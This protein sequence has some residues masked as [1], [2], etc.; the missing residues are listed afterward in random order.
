MAVEYIVL[1]DSP[2]ASGREEAAIGARALPYFWVE[3]KLFFK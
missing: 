1:F 2:C 3:A